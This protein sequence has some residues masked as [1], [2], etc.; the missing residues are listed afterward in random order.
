MLYDFI[1]ASLLDSASFDHFEE[2]KRKWLAMNYLRA[3]P[4]VQDQG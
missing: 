3:Q 1:V 2:N 4:T